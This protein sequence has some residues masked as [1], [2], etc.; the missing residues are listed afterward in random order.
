M[1]WI[2][3]DNIE[4]GA[5]IE[6]L[7]LVPTDR[8]PVEYADIG[9]Y[10]MPLIGGRLK[11]GWSAIFFKNNTALQVVI[12]TTPP[13][14]LDLP[15]E[16]RV[17]VGVVLERSAVTYAAHWQG[18]RQIWEI[19]HDGRWGKSQHLEFHGDLPS[20]FHSIRELEER[21]PTSASMFYVPLLTAEKLTGFLYDRPVED[22]FDFAN[23]MELELP[24]RQTR[25]LRKVPSWW[26]A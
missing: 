11:S 2:F 19:M 1:S 15:P 6:T 9:T 23:M 25:E 20:E 7:N 22:D 16:C 21:A 18:G 5:L 3:V 24:S 14:M 12:G 8:R 17:V 4:P 26:E 10:N 13:R